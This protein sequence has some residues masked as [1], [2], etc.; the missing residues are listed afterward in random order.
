MI[1]M[2]AVRIVIAAAA[3]MAF[4][5]PAEARFWQCVTFAR[6]ASGIEIYGNAHTWW[7]QAAGR[8]AR[9]AQPREGAVLA[10]APGGSSR[11]GHVAMVSRVLNDREILLT[12]A[13]WSRRGAVE[14]DVLAVDVSP[15]GDWSAVKIWYAPMGGLGGTVYRAHGFI[16]GDAPTR[17]PSLLERGTTFANATRQRQP[18]VLDLSAERAMAA[19]GETEFSPSADGN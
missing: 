17:E 6:A 10:I 14:R 19:A 18:L 13:N 16:Y 3:A 12:H 2:W 15:N 4:A 11:L 9:G 7:D 5:T 1:G 8:Y